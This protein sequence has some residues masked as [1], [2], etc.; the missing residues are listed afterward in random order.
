[1]GSYSETFN[2]VQFPEGRARFEG[3]CRCWDEQGRETFALELRGNEYFGEI[4]RSYLDN[5]NDYNIVID[6][7]GYGRGGDVGMP[8]I[9]DVDRLGIGVREVFTPEEEAVARTLVIQLVNA[10]LK[11]NPPPSPLKQIDAS[12]FMG[13]IGFHI[14]WMLLIQARSGAV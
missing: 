13:K 2:W 1:M 11:F 6:S 9:A 7:F 5:E 3:L 10:G 4:K 12:H 8:G 14:G